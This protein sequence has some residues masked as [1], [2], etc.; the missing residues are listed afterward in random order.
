MSTCRLRSTPYERWKRT[1]KYG[2]SWRGKFCTT[3]RLG[4]TEFNNTVPIVPAGT[5]AVQEFKVQSSTAHENPYVQFNSLQCADSPPLFF[6]CGRIRPTD[7]TQHRLC[8]HHF[9]QRGGVHCARHRYLCEKRPG[10]AAD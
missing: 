10:R 3:I 4:S 7:Q 8:W 5:P 2:Q 9:G 6:M 1:A